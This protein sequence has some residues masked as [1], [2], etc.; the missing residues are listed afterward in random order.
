MSSPLKNT[1]GGTCAGGREGLSA[2]SAVK[3]VGSES[4]CNSMNAKDP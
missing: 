4:R 3:K 1:E 2:K